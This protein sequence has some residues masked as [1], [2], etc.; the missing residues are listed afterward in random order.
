[1]TDIATIATTAE[2]TV[3]QIM[4][5]EPMIAGIAGMFVPGLSMVQPWIVMI[6]PYLE[7]ALNDVSTSNGGD[8]LGALVEL[9]Q[10]VSK[11]GPNSPILSATPAPAGS[12]VMP[13][14]P[15]V[16]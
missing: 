2:K 14:P 5:V 3:E 9:M 7:R 4:K 6:A 12:M 16:G 15:N 1:M 8:V 11:G 10:H 13:D